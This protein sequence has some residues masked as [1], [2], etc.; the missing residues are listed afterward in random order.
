[1]DRKRPHP[2]GVHEGDRK[3][4]VSPSA[5]VENGGGSRASS[6]KARARA[7][8]MPGDE[9]DG[10][11]DS[12][13]L[14]VETFQKEAIYRQ[15][16]EY[17]R[18]HTR[19]SARVS[20]L[21]RRKHALEAGLEGVEVCWSELLEAVR[22]LVGSKDLPPV[23]DAPS[24]FPSS[25]TSLPELSSAINRRSQSTKQLLVK[26]V[27]LAEK[28]ARASSD[29]LRE[30]FGAE[31]K[32]SATLRSSVKLLQS[33]L[34]LAKQE[35]E[36]TYAEL[37]RAEKKLDR[38]RC[39]SVQGV[40]QGGRPSP[41]AGPGPS[42]GSIDAD[43]K[44]NSREA[45]VVEQPP[46]QVNG[47]GSH[48][49]SPQTPG[50]SYDPEDRALA[51]SRLEE[52]NRMRED[53]VRLETTADHLR[54]Q[55]EHPAEAVVAQ[56][57]L[58]KSLMV[59]LSYFQAEAK[60]AKSHFDKLASEADIL[61]DGRQ[62]FEESAVMEARQ[63]VDSLRGQLS[64]KESDLARLR[65]QRDDLQAELS[66]RRASE[67]AN[68]KHVDEIVG[69]S[70]SHLTRIETL[71]SEIRR[72]KAKIA[73]STGGSESLLD[74]L[75]SEGEGDGRGGTLSY[76]RSLESKLQSSESRINVLADQIAHVSADT[77][78]SDALANESAARTALAEAQRRLESY[79]K[80]LGPDPSVGD[81]LARMGKKLE[82]KQEALR[83]M[84]L[85]VK[86][87]EAAT[88]ALY[89]EV[90]RLSKS[91]EDVANQANSKVLN[92]K[93]M[94]EKVSKL[95]TE[96]AKADNKYFAAMRTKEAVE[97]ERKVAQRNVE[98]QIKVLEKLSE[99]ERNLT[100]QL[101]LQEKEATILKASIRQFKDRIMELERE[102]AEGKVRLES[103]RTRSADMGKL[104]TTR[105]AIAEKE[106]ATQLNLQEELDRTKRDLERMT[107]KAKMV[108]SGVA[109]T[110]KEIELQEERNKLM[111]I[112]QCSTCSL[113]LR[114][115]CITKCMHTFCKDCIDAR[116]STRQRKCPACNLGFATSDV[117][118][119][120]FQ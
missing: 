57:V 10:E 74:F 78:L 43:S 62:E 107:A 97:V 72:L 95:A 54:F 87:N 20:E 17:Q 91:W 106:R 60:E 75:L 80:V 76:V 26:F 30:R 77:T 15:M 3:R 93:E 31:H 1:M 37:V 111:A 68:F 113:R 40:E 81:D 35:Q 102:A 49:P 88:D 6:S 14:K 79:E 119:I 39:E 100:T 110:G 59:Q 115:H 7:A 109:S 118:Q 38:I 22:G 4:R 12:L 19:S 83:V 103:E 70:N 53:R 23:E 28:G 2:D 89:G 24:A 117:Q 71:H 13:S 42:N 94:E 27:E 34:D 85:K 99:S 82:E 21:E 8:M 105:T 16:R 52:I 92:L 25:S 29:E 116:V 65:G 96:K 58:F 69:L 5:P 101:S 73:A 84:D 55:A 120:Y 48:L 36:K 66:E 90:E 63:D 47:N 33:Q 112:L 64:K 51:A 108:S 104:L 11:M 56:H 44:S 114:S 45:S 86:E 98:K 41:S 50:P 61:R 67:I 32:Q 46:P 18:Q 9:E